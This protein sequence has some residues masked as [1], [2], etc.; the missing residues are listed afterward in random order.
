MKMSIKS[1]GQGLY[2]AW[3]KLL[4]VIG[5]IKVFKFP[6]FVVYDNDDYKMSGEAIQA[7][8]QALRP[9]D[10]VLRGYDHYLD[11]HFIK[12]DYSHGAIYVGDGQIVHAVSPK[13]ES[14]H[15]I[16]FMMCDRIAIMRP[17]DQGLVAE[18]VER[19][20]EI[21]DGDTS[22]DFDFDAGD[23]TEVYC[24]ELVARCYPEI[25]FKKYGQKFLGGL[26]R[27]DTY[28]AS[29]FIESDALER[30]FEYN[31]RKGTEFSAS[32]TSV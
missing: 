12:G 22:Y 27:R 8:Q 25:E 31:P 3:S 24:F 32:K 26:L 28:L 7:A 11:G 17:K 23:P 21:L 19:A 2:S 14:I 6:L 10:I 1:L 13:V 29:S 9:G 5:D 4:D 30:V 18:A 15:P 20:R 16:S